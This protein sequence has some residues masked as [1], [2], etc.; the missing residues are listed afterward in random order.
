MLL[1]SAGHFVITKFSP[2]FSG[3]TLPPRYLLIALLAALVAGSNLA[4]VAKE[5]G[6]AHV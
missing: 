2:S 3:W 4:P 5:I 1:R 6:R